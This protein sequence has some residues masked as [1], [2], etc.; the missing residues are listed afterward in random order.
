MPVFV[1]LR[2]KKKNLLFTYVAALAVPAALPLLLCQIHVSLQ[3]VAK[4][5]LWC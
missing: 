4:V 1:T 5:H 3:T 2:L